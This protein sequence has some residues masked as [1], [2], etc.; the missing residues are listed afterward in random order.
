MQVPFVDLRTPH[1]VL[2][3]EL[4]EAIQRVLDRCDFALGQDV[5]LLEEEFATY[6]G[7]K[8]AIG[9]GSGL[10]ALELSLRAFGVGPGHEVIVPAHTFTATA[11]AVTFAG[12]VPVLVDVDPTTYN[13]D[14]KQIEAA[15]TPRTRAII[16]V[17]L[18]GL[19]AN[20]DTLM[21]IASKHNLFVVEDACQAH[22]ALYKGRRTGSLGHAAAFSFYPTKNLGAGGD[23]GIIVTDDDEVAEAARAM[24][25]CGQRVK[26]Q[27]ELHPFNHRL[28]TMQAAILRVKLKHLDE[29]NEGRR[30]A[31]QL[32][33][34]LL[35]DSNVVV[36]VESPDSQH[37][38]HLYVIR[39]PHR[40]ALREYLNSQGIGSAIHYP[41]PI[42]KQP[43]YSKSEIRYGALPETDKLVGEILSLPMFPEMTKEQVAYV[44]SHVKQFSPVPEL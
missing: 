23:G 3:D 29:W 39:T 13:I 9:V 21:A 17:H 8:H 44:A 37:V 27:H 10:A 41:N 33:S 43:F 2:R 24:R 7:T 16:P 15:I 36:P 25:N 34:E 6:C 32:Y 26:N 11:A 1:R 19:P 28:D 30:Q 38:Y 22:G 12:A 35:A 18:Y 40:E 20:M 5:G 14:T 42:H 4:N 31:A